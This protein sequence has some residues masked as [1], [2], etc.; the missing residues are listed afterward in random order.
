MNI[1]EIFKLPQVTLNDMIIKMYHYNQL[2]DTAILLRDNVLADICL[3]NVLE[4]EKMIK[5]L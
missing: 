4:L 3:E 1:N 2:F 5:E